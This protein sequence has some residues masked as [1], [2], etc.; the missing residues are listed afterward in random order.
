M[1]KRV[2]ELIRVS[3]EG[4]AGGDRASIPAQR[5]VNRR[6]A[7]TYGLE[8]TES[9]ELVNVSGAAVLRTPEMQRLLKTIEN[10][11]VHGVVV[12]EFSRVMR[13][14][15]FADYVLLQAFQDTGTVLY[16]PDG[17][18]DFASKTGRFMGSIR[19]AVAGLERSEILERV[20]TAKEEK[21]RAGQHPQSQITLP[22]GVG[23]EPKTK[24]WFYK[25]EV[26]KVREAVRLFL[27][28]ETSYKDVGRTVG[29]DAFNL[30]VILRNPIYTGWRVYA[31]RRDP[32]SSAIRARADGRQSDRR[33]IAR[34]P[35]DVIRVKVLEPI[36]SDGDFRRL[37]QIMDLKKQNHW[38]ARPDYEKRFTYSGFLRCGKCGDRVYT[39]GRQGRDWY[40]CKSRTA[41]SRRTRN[42]RGITDCTNPYMRRERLEE[43]IDSL[44][45]ER[46]TNRNFLKR[47]AF[48]HMHHTESDDLKPEITRMEKE[49]GQLKEKKQRI[50][51]AYFE[52]LIDR[53]ERDR[54]LHSLDTDGKL[55]GE[56]LLRRKP[57]TSAVSVTELAEMFAVFHE[58]EFLSV[59]GK[60]KLLRSTTPQIHVQDYRV[61][62]LSLVPNLMH[63]GEVNH[64]GKG[65]WPP[66]A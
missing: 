35:E 16:L 26:E 23:Y 11:M 45:A 47:L 4:Q 63:G 39:H 31:Q 43:C 62:G 37:Q 21:R 54:R 29:I 17:P 53:E 48:E 25:P 56:L 20:W 42:E 49:L 36:V 6:T 2:I 3:T 38:R 28:G 33:K 15:N 44:F 61:V 58:W 10:P 30:R 32:S 60:R 55:Y 18:I 5:A 65:S 27:A 46:L 14:D 7:Q 51:D 52:N 8:I 12:R 19:A 57:E 1:M 64:T 13:P 66:P 41:E 9:I 40:V 24:Q 50:L 34:A 22:F 59:A